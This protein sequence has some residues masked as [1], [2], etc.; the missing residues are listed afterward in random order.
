MTEP[1]SVRL[2]ELERE[3]NIFGSVFV[4]YSGYLTI[5]VSVTLPLRVYEGMTTFEG[6]FILIIMSS[7]PTFPWKSSP[8]T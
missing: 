7:V 1:R 5:L 2:R 8:S 3:E 6:T 4:P